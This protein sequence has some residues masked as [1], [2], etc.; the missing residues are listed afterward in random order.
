MRKGLTTLLTVAIA[1]VSVQAMALAPM[2][3]DI[4]SPIVGNSTG[5][6]Q[7]TKFIYVDAFDLDT[8]VEDDATSDGGLK[9]SYEIVGTAKYTINGNASLVA[10]DNP[11]APPTAKLIAGPGAG[12]NQIVGSTAAPGEDGKPNTVTIRNINMYPYGGSPSADQSATAQLMATHMQVVTFWCSD[13]N[14]AS[15]KDVIFY[16][17]NQYTGGVA[18]GWNRLSG[19]IPTG[20]KQV[21]LDGATNNWKMADGDFATRKFYGNMTSSTLNGKGIC[22]NVTAAGDNFGSVRSV[23]PYF[24]LT[25]NQV[26]R[27]RAKMNCSQTAPG[28]T[29]FWNFILENWNGDGTVGMNLYG[30]ETMF[31][32]NEGGANSIVSTTAGT[33]VYMYWAPSALLTPQWNDATNGVFIAAHAAVKDPTLRF[34]VMDVDT[35]AALLNNL[36]SGSIC[37]QSVLVESIGYNT[38]TTVQNVVNITA[39]KDATLAGG[40]MLANGLAGAFCN[41][42]NPTNTLTITPAGSGVSNE[43]VEVRPATNTVYDFPGNSILDDWPIAWQ[44]G[45][46][47]Q[48]SVKLSAPDA[49][50][51]ARPFDVMWLNMAPPTNE[52]ITDSLLTATA[53]PRTGATASIAMP[54]AGT[55]QDY[56]MFYYTG[57]ETKSATANLHNL[58]WRLTFANSQNLNWPA[59]SITTNTGSV[60]LHSVK[61]DLVQFPN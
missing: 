31:V 7:A 10:A 46:L 54:K 1:L 39:P 36:K 40:N 19:T 20:W 28:K 15:M 24:S 21:K 44:S 45:K 58:R 41:Y 27:I 9:W 61:V 56:I 48:L 30:M 59:P 13:G 25:A 32:D 11:I 55:P 16:T 4:P 38:M 49:T 57:K 35:N 3:G 8:L 43:L 50:N 29:P 26:Y 33:D 14:L 42:N 12:Q 6:S 47:Y 51:E 5:A 23:Q 22:I 18:T 17:D 34:R 37:L 53:G 2:I 60:R 52:V